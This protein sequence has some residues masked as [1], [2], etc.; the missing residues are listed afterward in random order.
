MHRITMLGTGLIGA[1]YTMALH[2]HRGRD[3]VHVAYSRSAERAK[4]FAEQWGI[5]KHT[6]SLEEAV[7]EQ[8]AGGNGDAFHHPLDDAVASDR[9]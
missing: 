9:F 1:F 7:G 4:K 2:G 6:T 5:P 8:L 3:R